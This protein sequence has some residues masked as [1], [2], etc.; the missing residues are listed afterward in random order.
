MC[1]GLRVGRRTAMQVWT[2]RS[3]LLKAHLRTLLACFSECGELAKAGTSWAQPPCSPASPTALPTLSQAPLHRTSCWSSRMRA[4]FRV[5]SSWADCR[6]P[7]C[8]LEASVSVF[9]CSVAC[10]RSSQSMTFCQ[11]T[12]PAEEDALKCAPPVSIYKALLCRI[13]KVLGKF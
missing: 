10:S 13:F 6:S 5:S 4:S 7:E 11:G 1:Q 12:R 9:S 3:N 8:F 2:Q